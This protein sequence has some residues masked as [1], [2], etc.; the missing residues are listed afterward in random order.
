MSHPPFLGTYAVTPTQGLAP[1]VLYG[2]L[3]R[4]AGAD[5]TIYPT[6]GLKFPISRPDCAQIAFACTESWVP[7]RPIFPTA[8]GRMG[9]DRIREMCGLYGHDCVFILGSQI[10]ESPEGIAVSCE[11]FMQ[12]LAKLSAAH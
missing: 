11:R 2:R 7:L 9:E 10:R 8:A 3:P 6:Y 12:R 5:I 4:L 1:S